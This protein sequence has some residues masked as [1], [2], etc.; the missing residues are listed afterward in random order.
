MK[1][2]PF[3][4]SFL[5]SVCTIPSELVHQCCSHHEFVNKFFEV[6]FLALVTN[7]SLLHFQLESIFSILSLSLSLLNMWLQADSNSDIIYRYSS[8]QASLAPSNCLPRGWFTWQKW[9]FFLQGLFTQKQRPCVSTCWRPRLNLST[10]SCI[11]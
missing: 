4:W 5:Q 11:W 8:C 7:F 3:E 10:W 6:L 1:S 2:N 9:N